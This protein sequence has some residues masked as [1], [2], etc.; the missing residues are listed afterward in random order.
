MDGT[1]NK[2]LYSDARCFTLYEL[3]I[4]SSLP[5]NWNIP[6]WI[7]ESE[8]RKIIGEGIPSLLV[9]YIFQELLINLQNTK[10]QLAS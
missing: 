9:K 6:D 8:I 10:H 7:K 5:L 4:I 1:E 3:L 2:R